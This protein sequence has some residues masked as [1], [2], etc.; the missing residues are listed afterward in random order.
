MDQVVSCIIDGIEMGGFLAYGSAKVSQPNATSSTATVRIYDP[1]GRWE[2]TLG[3]T[4]EI[5][6]VFPYGLDFIGSHIVGA[7]SL[8]SGDQ[9]KVT[10]FGGTVRRFT[11]DT[12]MHSPIADR[13][14]DFVGAARLGAEAVGGEDDAIYYPRFISIDATDYSH[15]FGRMLIN[16]TWSSKTLKQIVTDV[17]NTDMAEFGLSIDKVN[18]GPLIAE[19][20]AEYVSASKIM[21]D[22]A[23]ISGYRWWVDNFKNVWFAPLST[24]FGDSLISDHSANWQSITVSVSDDEYRNK[25]TVVLDDG[26]FVTRSNSSEITARGTWWFRDEARGITSVGAGNAYGDGLLRQF[27]QIPRVATIE[28]RDPSFRVGDQVSIQLRRYGLLG[29][30]MI[31]ERAIHILGQKIDQNG[32]PKADIIY[33]LAISKGERVPNYQEYFARRLGS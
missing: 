21:N 31:Q 22:L 13:D 18:T 1:V 30:Y 14:E 8:G 10:L 33:S 15:Y 20:T 27:A 29:A 11:I 5:A 12:L 26:S 4:I 2:P 23:A 32:Q 17:V 6:E 7:E 19:Y 16:R 3:A 9:A 28:T 25:V 24:V